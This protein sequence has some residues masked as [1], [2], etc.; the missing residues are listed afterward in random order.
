MMDIPSR[1][2]SKGMKVTDE[3]STPKATFFQY[4]YWSI[5]FKA[6]EGTDFLPPYTFEVDQILRTEHIG[7]Q[8]YQTHWQTQQKLGFVTI[9]LRDREGK[10]LWQLETE[11]FPALLHYKEDF[12]VIYQDLSMWMQALAFRMQGATYSYLK[13][14]LRKHM[15]L[16]ASLTLWM[17]WI[18]QWQMA[19]H[20]IRQHPHSLR[21]K[22]TETLPIHKILK[23]I[24]PK[25][26]QKKVH[27]IPATVW[28]DQVDTEVNRWVKWCIQKVETLSPKSEIGQ[29]LHQINQFFL[30]Q[31]FFQEVSSVPPKRV[32]QLT[33]L[34]EAYQRWFQTY[35]W[36][37]RNLT[38]SHLPIFQTTF[39]DLPRLY[40]YWAFL[41]LADL[42]AGLTQH[43]L[44]KQEVLTLHGDHWQSQLT[45]GQAISLTFRSLT[46]PGT[47]KLWYN[48]SFLDLALG[49]QRPDIL[50]EIKHAPEETPFWIFFDAKYRVHHV[51]GKWAAPT[52]SLNQMHRY[53]DAI[54]TQIHPN[55][56]PK[57]A[58]KAMAGVVLFP[59]PLDES[60]FTAHP[61]FLS[62]EKVGIGALPLRPGEPEATLLAGYISGLLNASVEALEEQ[63]I[64]YRLSPQRIKPSDFDA[65]MVWQE[66][67]SPARQVE[68]SPSPFVASF[69]F[70]G[71]FIS[72]NHQVQFAPVEHLKIKDAG[73]CAEMGSWEAHIFP[74][75]LENLML[76][77]WGKWGGLRAAQRYQEPKLMLLPTYPAY[78]VWQ[79]L[80]TLFPTATWDMYRQESKTVMRFDVKGKEIEW[81]IEG[82]QME[83]F[84]DAKPLATYTPQEILRDFMERV[85]TYIP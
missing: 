55:M 49:N 23:P 24:A 28:Q 11:I 73:F 42:L 10:I 61:Q 6:K 46:G 20:D 31:T 62:L 76:P 1:W 7:P 17:H 56:G 2:E 68:I 13:P 18:T 65:T 12:Q 5:Q 63:L 54:V 84:M 59:Y 85:F 48:R 83:V 43:Q 80:R 41:K 79:K 8:V 39:K 50:L 16:P 45:Q 26:P 21:Y 53:R 36:L 60:T 22:K 58:Q 74:M 66:N 40:E 29:Q 64:Q 25:H 33:Y 34:P 38:L 19:L 4:Q 27:R 69:Q 47:L 35:L 3:T 44:D 70:V 51:Q 30:Q 81:T 57:E 37:H 71:S 14:G 15:Q 77:M 75:P 9:A 67:L 78:R 52:A 32:P 72:N 82:E